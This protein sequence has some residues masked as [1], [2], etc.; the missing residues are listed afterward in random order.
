MAERAGADSPYARGFCAGIDS[1]DLVSGSIGSKALS[2]LDYTVLGD[3]VNVAA[4][5][6]LIAEPAQILITETVYAAIHTA[7]DCEHRGLK[8]LPGE[9]ELSAVYRVLNRSA[10]AEHP[11]EIAKTEDPEQSQE[12][13][14]SPFKSSERDSP[15][16][17][18][19]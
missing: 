5:L 1:G 10:S 18:Q 11:G 13:E 16:T 9:K 8:E 7:F 3:A 4:H 19:P 2:R 14:I 12:R 6:E 17:H 15:T